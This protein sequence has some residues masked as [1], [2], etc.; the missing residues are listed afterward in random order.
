MQPDT[1][2]VSLSFLKQKGLTPMYNFFLLSS[3]VVTNEKQAKY[4]NISPELF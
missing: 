4:R 2:Y 1:V 3:T